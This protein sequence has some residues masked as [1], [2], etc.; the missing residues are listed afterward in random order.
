MP[1]AAQ[2]VKYSLGEGKLPRAAWVSPGPNP[3]F[4]MMPL[5]ARAQP[6]YHTIW[7]LKIF[8][9]TTQWRE[10]A[11]KGYN[12]L[13]PYIY[14]S[15]HAGQV[16]W[17]A[18]HAWASHQAWHTKHVHTRGVCHAMHMSAR[19]CMAKAGGPIWG[20]VPNITYFMTRRHE[21]RAVQIL[22]PYNLDANKPKHFSFQT[23]FQEIQ[24][25]YLYDMTIAMFSHL[26]TYTY[27]FTCPIL[28]MTPL[29]TMQSTRTAQLE[30]LNAQTMC[31]PSIDSTRISPYQS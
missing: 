10:R 9:A 13:Y 20:L 7:G 5:Y 29:Q 26:S 12:N 1:G 14:L 16:V 6:S 27:H 11:F 24:C 21:I 8:G 25:L 23:R 18:K 22:L 15:L 30:S 31:S 4:L 3:F 17:H 19:H 2:D 28:L